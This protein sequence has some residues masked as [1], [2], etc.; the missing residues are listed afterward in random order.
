MIEQCHLVWRDVYGYV[1]GKTKI[2]V[3]VPMTNQKERHTYFGP[4]NYQT[5]QFF[6]RDDGTGNSENT[7]LFVK[8]LQS[9]NIG[10]RILIFWDGQVIINMERRNYLSLV[11]Q[12]LEISEWSIMYELFAPNALL[13]KP[14][15]RY[16][17]SRQNSSQKT[18]A[19]L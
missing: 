15:R 13:A 11:N 17:A 14:C 19:S 4:L 2:R 10:A 16:L 9:L 18:L 1:W 8:Y 7:V 5:K 6:V 12:D 3:K